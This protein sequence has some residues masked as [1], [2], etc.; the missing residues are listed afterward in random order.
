MKRSWNPDI[1]DFVNFAKPPNNPELLEK[2]ELSDKRA[3]K[4]TQKSRSLS[5][6]HPAFVN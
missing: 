2:F 4:P 6:G 1:E 3:F 5:P